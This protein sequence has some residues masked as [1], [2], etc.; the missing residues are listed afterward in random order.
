MTL[1]QIDQALR[2]MDCMSLLPRQLPEQASVCLLVSVFLE[3]SSRSHL[4]SHNLRYCQRFDRLSWITVT[5]GRQGTD[6]HA[7]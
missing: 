4:Y 6:A 7:A 2:H 5:A 3:S 1:V